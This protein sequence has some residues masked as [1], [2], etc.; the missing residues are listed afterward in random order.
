MRLYLHYEDARHAATIKVD[1]AGSPALVTCRDLLAHFAELY[2]ARNTGSPCLE[3]DKLTLH[4]EDQ[5]PLALDAPVAKR[6]HNDDDLFVS[7]GTAS[8]DPCPEDATPLPPPV[9]PAD[10]PPAEGSLVQ[11]PAGEEADPDALLPSQDPD[12]APTNPVIAEFMRHSEAA[13]AKRSNARALQLLAQV[14]ALFPRHVAAWR[15]QGQIYASIGKWAAAVRAYTA[16]ARWDTNDAVGAHIALGDAQFHLGQ[17]AASV[18]ALNQALN[19][20]PTAPQPVPDEVVDDLKAFLGR[21]LYRVGEQ[22]AGLALISNVV[23]THPGHQVALMEYSQIALDRA[24]YPEAV[25]IALNL[26]V[27][28]PND[29]KARAFMGQ[30][31]AR[32]PNP[33]EVLYGE[34]IGAAESPPALAF[35]AV[36]IKDQGLLPESV[37]LYRKA[38]QGEPRNCSYALNYAH[39][40]EVVNQ[41]LAAIHVVVEFLRSNPTASLSNLTSADVLRCLGDPVDLSPASTLPEVPLEGWRARY[42]NVSGS[43]NHLTLAIPEG[44]DL[45]PPVFKT[46]PK[47]GKFTAEELDL[48]ALMFTLVK[49][50][51]VTGAL[52][53][54]PPLL[55]LLD[56]LRRG[57]E[58]HHTTIRNE[59]AY[60]CNIAQ[61][62]QELP[63]AELHRDRPTKVMYVCGDSHSL[64]PSWRI[65]HHHGQPTRLVNALVTGLKCWHLRPESRFYPKY[66]FHSVV[67]GIPEGSDVIM[68]FGEI[69]CRE[70]LLLAVERGIYADLRE[71]MQATINIYLD[72][73]LALQQE[74]QFRLFVHPALPMLDVTRGTVKLFNAMLEA[75]LGRLQ[76]PRIHWLDF[77]T[78]V[79][80]PDGQHL[81]PE[82]EL[83]GTH[84]HP[85]YLPLVEAALNALPA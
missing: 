37:E 52:V 11:E 62:M 44:G 75:A 46:V 49:N 48:L 82:Y 63:F 35:L 60:F 1:T 20:I 25:R 15:L 67:K 6:F 32:I 10:T 26:L 17:H 47:D 33:L 57:E 73:L 43:E 19:A 59:Q 85:R 79:L 65:I 4:T 40:L 81:R 69:D 14:L 22:E 39:T 2:N 16:A 9:I 55:A 70:G 45:S 76:H 31:L 12:P 64:S 78:Q 80:T 74:R 30:T 27:S 77:Y 61:L 66:N 3:V 5:E 21:A 34:L 50:L 53:H 68:I 8:A 13:V 54:V 29:K 18:E 28:H 84:I 24:K 36:V 58:L 41:H 23:E 83:D 42:L 38:A 7:S 56:P 72:S 71:G 51:F